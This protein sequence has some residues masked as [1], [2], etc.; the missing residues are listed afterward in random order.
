[1]RGLTIE[2][3]GVGASAE[4]THD[5]TLATIREFVAASGDANPIHSDER[6]AAETRFGRIIA[7]GMLTGSFVSAVIGTTLPGPGTVYLSQSLRFLRPVYVG[8][9]VTARVEVVERVADRARLRLRTTCANQ[10]GD[11]VLEGEAWVRPP[12]SPIEYRRPVGG[13]PAALALV[14]IALAAELLSI[15]MSSGLALASCAVALGQRALAGGP[16]T[17]PSGRGEAEPVRP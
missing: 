1:M 14:P 17:G 10:R 13:R 16:G 12:A 6:F 5:V 8:D 11:L 7:P 2:D 9:R 3:L 15:W 4:A